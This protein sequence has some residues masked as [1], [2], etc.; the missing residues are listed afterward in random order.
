MLSELGNSLTKSLDT[1]TKKNN[2][3]YFTPKNIVNKCYELLTKYID[4][5]KRNTVFNSLS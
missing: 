2:G 3:I 4:N 1:K 5:E